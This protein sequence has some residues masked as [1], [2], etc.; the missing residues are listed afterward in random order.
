MR[1]KILAKLKAKF[2]GLPIAFLGLFADKMATTVTEEDK[3]DGAIATL[4][5][6][7]VPLPDL[8]ADWQKEGDRRVADAKKEWDKKNPKPPGPG[9]TDPPTNEPPETDPNK[10]LLQT[11]QNLAKQVEEM[12]T[13]TTQKTLAEKLHAKLAEKKI[14]LVYAKGRIPEKEEDIETLVAE[15]EADHQAVK[16]DLINQ[17]FSQQT[18]PVGGESAIQKPTGKEDADIHKWAEQRKKQANTGKPVEAKT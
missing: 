9:K 5:T 7:P 11:V 16:Q 12:R 17:G 2:S 4:D 18:P 8:A 13:H 14:P 6:L 10:I 1:E 3:I 15:I